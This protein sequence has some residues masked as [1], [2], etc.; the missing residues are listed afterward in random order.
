MRR[1]RLREAGE[2][3]AACRGADGGHR[4][5]F[6]FRPN[7]SRGHGAWGCGA[8]VGASGAISKVRL[9]ARHRRRHMVEAT[10]PIPGI[11]LPSLFRGVIFFIFL[12]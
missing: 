1:L 6:L 8:S 4:L 3:S 7:L 11:R 2:S 5:A 12:I 10:L 9:A